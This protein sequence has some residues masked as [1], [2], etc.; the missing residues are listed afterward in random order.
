M[1]KKISRGCAV[2]LACAMLAGLLMTT[3]FARASDYLALYSVWATAKSDGVVRIH[4]DVEAVRTSDEVGVSYITV[5]ESDDGGK[6]WTT[7]KKYTKEDLNMYEE[8]TD[9][10]TGP[11]I[12]RIR[13]SDGTTVPWLVCTPSGTAA[14]TSAP[15]TPT[16]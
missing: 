12:L 15:S 16:R 11:S 8:N 6:T 5:Q 9:F 3:A 7:L 13:S 2:L 14:G 1:K 4:A 10:I